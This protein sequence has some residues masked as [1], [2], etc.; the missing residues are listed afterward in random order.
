[1]KKLTAAIVLSLIMILSLGGVVSAATAEDVFTALEDANVPEAYILQAEAYFDAHPMTDAQ[2]GVIL[3][4]IDAALVIANGKTKASE[5]TSAQRGEIF[6]ELVQAG[7]V[8]NLTVTYEG[9]TNY[10]KGTVYVRDAQN[11]VVFMVTAEDVIK[12]TGFDYSIFLYGLLILAVAGAS[13][14]VIRRKAVKNNA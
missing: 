6:Q 5:L 4:H 7:N 9:S 13:G 14:L 11:N 10:E 12:H 8:L 3:Q 2:A 1:M